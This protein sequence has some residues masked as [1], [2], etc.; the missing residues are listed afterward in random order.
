MSAIAAAITTEVLMVELADNSFEAVYSRN[1]QPLF[2]MATMMV[3]SRAEGEELAQEAFTRWYVRKGSVDNPDAYLRTI[4][5]NLCRG[6]YRRRITV[7]KNAHFFDAPEASVTIQDPLMDVIRNLP[8]RQRAAV[9]LRFYDGR[10]EHEIARIL[11][12][13][14][15]TVRSLLSRAMATLRTEVER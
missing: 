7:A 11:E 3:G 2:R 6:N 4:V 10:D 14:P 8:I 12:C 15:G 13:R 5:L 1:W 9:I